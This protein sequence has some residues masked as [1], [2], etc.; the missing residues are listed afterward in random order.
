MLCNWL[1]SS[2]E[3]IDDTLTVTEDFV[4]LVPVTDTTT[5]VDIFTALVRALDRVGVPPPLEHC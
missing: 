3:N 5:A 2:V 4:E 1:Y